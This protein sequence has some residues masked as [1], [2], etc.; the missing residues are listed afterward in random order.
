MSSGAEPS[1]GIPR[2]L[3]PIARAFHAMFPDVSPLDVRRELEA[4]VPD[5]RTRLENLIDRMR[6]EYGY[7][8]EV[9]E[10]IRS[11]TRQDALFARGRTAPGPVVTWTRTSPHQ[12][13]RAADV[14]IDG[15]Y[16][17][18]PAFQ[19]L[20][21]VARELGLRTLWP[22]DPGHIEL[23][24]SVEL[25][26][27]RVPEQ[28]A[29][30]AGIDHAV[31]RE[32]PVTPLTTLGA[33]DA[34][35]AAPNVRPGP[36]PAL[37]TAP[38]VA[39]SPAG[40][41]PWRDVEDPVRT[42]ARVPSAP[43]A[44]VAPM[45]EVER[46]TSM[47]PMPM[48]ERPASMAPMPMV[49]RPAALLTVAAAATV[50]AV[51]PGAT[52][53]VVA[54]VATVS[55]TARVAG[56]T[57][58]ARAPAGVTSDETPAPRTLARSNPLGDAARHS[59]QGLPALVAPESPDLASLVPLVPTTVVDRVIAAVNAHLERGRRNDGH[60]VDERG[61]ERDLVAAVRER[62]EA[63]GLHSR[64]SDSSAFSRVDAAV[65]K[66]GM[67]VANMAER[68]AHALDVRDT[69]A[70][71]PL[72]SVLLRL[73]HPEGGEDRIR[74]ELRG[75]SVSTT[76]EVRDPI[77]ADRLSMHAPE[78]SRALAQHG[79]D[80]EQV[81][82]RAGRFDASLSGAAGNISERDGIRTSQSSNTSGEPS[83]RERDSR[84][85]S[86]GYNQPNG[87]DKQRHRRDSR[88]SR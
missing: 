39:R 56:M 86:R 6:N 44:A 79:L 63:T 65:G 23:P 8:V 15:G 11:Q 35:Q 71:R 22:R 55:A 70:E 60:A 49:E 62:V 34:G 4:L 61:A 74:V 16:A 80:P 12:E 26:A 13:G 14:K 29:G 25:S 19:R 24:A 52:A 3:A 30:R 37:A 88:G 57:P 66:E 1:P 81:T 64:S 50:A 58:L 59:V 54:Q 85:P 77:A 68:I 45:P 7:S 27:G 72:S 69:L 42:A 33:S 83:H 21:R 76:L 84:D 10:T 38:P 40:A 75:H 53:A 20:A 2:A 36:F 48:A 28:N 73:D 82:I 31:P 5:L 41:T 18:A 17:D 78:L 32:L 47:A 67:P 87:E 51:A 43:R 46:P 9:V